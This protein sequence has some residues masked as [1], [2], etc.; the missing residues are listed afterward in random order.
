MQRR[1]EANLEKAE[2][3]KRLDEALDVYQAELDTM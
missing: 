3:K 2:D 1:D